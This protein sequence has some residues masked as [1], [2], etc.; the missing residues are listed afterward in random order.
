M[1]EVDMSLLQSILGSVLGGTQ[2]A[3]SGGLGG[4]LLQIAMSMLSGQQGGQGGGLLE[5]LRQ[6]GMGNMLDSWIGKGENLPISGD[7]LQSILG[8]QQVADIASKL[9]IDPS[10]VGGQLSQILPDL[11][12]KLTP[13][14][15]LPQGGFGNADAIMGALQGML[16]R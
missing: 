16:K 4:P 13:D 9:G 12:D 8:S 14:G 15:Q 2:Q 3:Q 6:G 1:K 11:V 7:Q 10:A 5:Q